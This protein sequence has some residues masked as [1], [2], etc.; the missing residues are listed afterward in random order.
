MTDI[1]KQLRDVVAKISKAH[2]T[3][4]GDIRP[5][6]NSAAQEIERMRKEIEQLKSDARPYG[7]L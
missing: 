2:G 5:I 4:R 1:V 3:Y 7:E 6:F